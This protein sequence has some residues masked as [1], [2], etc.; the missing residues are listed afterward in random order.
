MLSPCVVAQDFEFLPE[1]NAY[2]SL[3]STVRLSFQAKQTRENGDP[4]QAEFGPSV[5]LLSKSLVKLKRVSQYDHDEAK[6]RLL[7]LSFGYRFLPSPD[8]PAV[9]R[10]LFEMT[11]HLP[12]FA[13]IL[14]DDRNRFELNFS[15]KP[16]DW[17]YRNRF[18]LQRTFVIHS[19]HPIP[20]A[21]V[22]FYYDSKY[23]KW[24]STAIYAG[25]RFPVVRHVQINPYYE[26]ENNTGKKPNQQ[27]NALGGVI[28]LYF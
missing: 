27:V 3:N 21:S 2:Y 16:F 4:T 11:P 15:S 17:R 20:Y 7:A 24:S 12:L 13:G 28:D 18:N 23:E 26:H 22:E 10:I 6:H 19:Y 8:A 14:L 9:H 5:E 25:C 1:I